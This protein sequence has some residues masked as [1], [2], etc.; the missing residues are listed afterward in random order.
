MCL[1][2]DTCL[3]ADPAVATSIR[4]QSHTFAEIDHEI[5]SKAIRLPFAVQEGFRSVTSESMFNKNWLT[6]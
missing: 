5:I 6:V 1:A 2:A 3:S 4:A